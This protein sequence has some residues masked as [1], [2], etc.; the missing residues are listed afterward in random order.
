MLKRLSKRSL[1]ISMMILQGMIALA[2]TRIS[3]KMEGNSKLKWITRRTKGRI[4][5]KPLYLRSKLAT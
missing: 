5:D 1:M 4:G 2:L 3:R